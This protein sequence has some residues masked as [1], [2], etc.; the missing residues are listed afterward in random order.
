MGRRLRRF[1]S[2][3]IYHVIQRGHNRSFIFKE[4]MD[5][6]C[7]LDCLK[8]ARKVL[9]FRV[10]YYALMSN[11][12]H[13]IVEIQ[14]APLEKAMHRTHL[15][16]SKY[17]NQKYE[18]TGTVYGERYRAYRV[19]NTRYL[20]K[21]ILYIANNPIKAGLASLPAEYRWCAHWEIV[22][23]KPGIVAKE[24]LFEVLGGTTENGRT[25]YDDLILQKYFP[26][27]QALT[28]SAFESEY[29]LDLLE[30]ILEEMLG[31]R[32]TVSGIR[33]GARDSF[34][35][36]LRR[37]FILLAFGQGFKPGEIART[38]NVTDRCVRML[39]S[40]KLGAGY[41]SGRDAK[42]GES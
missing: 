30:T 31:G 35:N 16:Y 7:F 20:L 4:P 29:R 26:V 19:A 39:T 10:L 40:Y 5:K 1:V 42:Q 6:D 32:S 25:T 13:L 21:L 15:A 28:D 34:S 24:R 14:S 36:Q 27:S 8:D 22:C 12:Y 11:H 3:E 37:E 38:L 33:S 41:E 2:G 17:Y 9:P 23:R 18:C